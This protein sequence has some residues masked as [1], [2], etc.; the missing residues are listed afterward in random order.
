MIRGVEPSRLF[1][2]IFVA[3]RVTPTRENADRVDGGP[4]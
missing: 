4:K 1:N 2:N 3:S